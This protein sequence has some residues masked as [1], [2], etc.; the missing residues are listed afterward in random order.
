MNIVIILMILLGGFSKF[1][2]KFIPISIGLELKTFFTILIAFKYPVL[3]AVSAFIMVMISSLVSMRFHY[4][5]FIKVA[6]YS[7]ISFIVYG[8]SGFGVVIA[9]KMAV[10]FLNAAYVF[11]NL[12][13]GN[14]SRTADL[15][16][17]AINIIFNFILLDNLSVYL[18]SLI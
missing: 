18:L 2:R 1:Y 7:I 8:L 11:I 17:N 9:G 14:Y 3:G 6:I 4:W 15:L 10:V 16:G 13:L 5:V 12:A